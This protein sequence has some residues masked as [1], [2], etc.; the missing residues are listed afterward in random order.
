MSRS[1]NQRLRHLTSDL[2]STPLL[3]E[4]D[5]R[6]AMHRTP[7]A[8]A[9]AVRP[10]WWSQHK[11]G[12]A[13]SAASLA[14]ASVIAVVLLPEDTTQTPPRTA[15]DSNV[16]AETT[17]TQD[18]ARTNEMAIAT[19]RE[20]LEMHDGQGASKPDVGSMDQYHRASAASNS[21]N[22]L[23][24]TFLQL[25]FE[26]LANLGLTVTARSIRYEEGAFRITVSTSGIAAQGAL[27]SEREHVTPRH[28]SLYRNGQVWAS[29]FDQDDPTTT[30]NDLIPVHVH[31]EA[32]S[33][34]MFPTAEA[35]L[36][37][38]PTEAFVKQ[39]TTVHQREI[40]KDLQSKN[41]DAI[42]VERSTQASRISGTSVF[43]NPARGTG[44]TLR[45]TMVEETITTAEVIDI[46]GRTV[47]RL[48]QD[49]RLPTG[50]H[51]REIGPL[52]DL[53]NGMYLIVVTDIQSGERLVQ[54]LLIER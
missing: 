52:M 45:M 41:G 40:G 18:R 11:G 31:L 34:A 2:E 15:E 13:I 7:S 24:T 8:P 23:S 53:A 49:L 14:V 27:P 1:L 21:P 50:Q 38:E 5:I 16:P 25:S 42:Y 17:P 4:A 44:A 19:S 6:E 33:N 47:V 12:L 3:T 46:N 30:P 51:D 9:P 36:W 32:P 26:E 48:W 20:D 43:P 37:Y 39:L 35:V 54:R 22:G 28:I 29:W 10:S